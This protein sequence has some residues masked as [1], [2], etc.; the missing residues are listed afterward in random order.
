VY[1]PHLPHEFQNFVAALSVQASSFLR[2]AVCDFGVAVARSI[3][4]ATRFIYV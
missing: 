4:E 1:T 3:L 2:L